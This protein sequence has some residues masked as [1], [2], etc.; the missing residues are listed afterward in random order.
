MKSPVKKYTISIAN[1]KC[2]AKK[3]A[4]PTIDVSGATNSGR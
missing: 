1:S 3:I 4:P 2:T